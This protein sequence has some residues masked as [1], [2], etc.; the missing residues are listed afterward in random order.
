MREKLE[1]TLEARKTLV[2]T[3]PAEIQADAEQ[4]LALIGWSE[5]SALILSL[6]T[7]CA[8]KD[9]GH[10]L[11]SR[12][13]DFRTATSLHICGTDLVHSGCD[14]LLDSRVLVVASKIPRSSHQPPIEGRTVRYKPHRGS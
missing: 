4:C 6:N 2:G 14:Y 3:L 8:L 13:I 7:A 12:V 1:S 9:P 11:L 10:L 5:K